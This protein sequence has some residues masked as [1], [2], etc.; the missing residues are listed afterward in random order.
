MRQKTPSGGNRTNESALDVAAGLA[1]QEECSFLKKRTKKLLFSQ[2]DSRQQ[3][4]VFC[5]FFH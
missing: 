5:F 1:A 2:E 3:E 4:K